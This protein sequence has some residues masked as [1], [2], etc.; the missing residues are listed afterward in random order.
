MND[1]SDGRKSGFSASII[2]ARDDWAGGIFT[3]GYRGWR[4]W[5]IV[6]ANTG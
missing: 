1:S 3:E 4:E 5:D 6:Y 2:V